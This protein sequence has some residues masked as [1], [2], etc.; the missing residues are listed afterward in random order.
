MRYAVLA[1]L[2]IFV[3]IGLAI[4]SFGLWQVLDATG[5]SSW[6]VSQGT[7]LRSEFL[8]ERE[9]DEQFDTRPDIAYRYRVVGKDFE[10]DT[11][12]K[13]INTTMT[14]SETRRWVNEHPVDKM[15]D[16]YVDPEDAT[17]AVLEPGIPTEA[18][19]F[20]AFGAIFTVVPT[21]IA[22][23]SWSA[24]TRRNSG[25]RNPDWDEDRADGAIG[26]SGRTRSGSGCGWL[27]A[28]VFFGIFL[29]V[30]LG[31]LNYA[32]PARAA[33]ARSVDWPSTNGTVIYRGVQHTTS[34]QENRT[35]HTYTP[36]VVYD[37]VI[38]DVTYTSSGIT[39]SDA[40]SDDRSDARKA[41]QPYPKGKQVEVFYDPTDFY[42]GTLKTGHSG[43]SFV[44]LILGYVFSA[45]GGLPIVGIA[46]VKLFRKL[47]I[48]NS[49][50]DFVD[51]ENTTDAYVAPWDRDD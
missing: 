22:L 51:T 12:R 29:C 40:G 5:S 9:T 39:L 44:L 8:I 23:V 45:V 19:L 31:M 6:P 20:I 14:P 17:N 7:V 26:R 48:G 10:S 43:G 25:A 32:I 18:W 1:F 33:E 27:I 28:I 24:V 47:S 36:N 13:G 3:F 35:E 16:V 2:S 34:E 15:V 46:I 11:L 42:N 37:Y 38:D 4:L 49:V 21:I 50:G 41:I 30:G